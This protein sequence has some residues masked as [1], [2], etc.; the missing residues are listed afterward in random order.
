[1]NWRP[2]GSVCAHILSEASWSTDWLPMRGDWVKDAPEAELMMSL[3]MR[4]TL[5]SWEK[6]KGRKER[7]RVSAGFPIKRGL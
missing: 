5:A 2:E 1:M 7:E 4:W 3:K 6:G